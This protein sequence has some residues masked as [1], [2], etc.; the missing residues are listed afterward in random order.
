MKISTPS[1]YIERFKRS[2]VLS[3]GSKYT[4]KLTDPLPLFDGSFIYPKDYQFSLKHNFY[5]ID[6]EHGLN[7]KSYNLLGTVLHYRNAIITHYVKPFY[8]DNTPIPNDIEVVF[9]KDDGKEVS[10]ELKER[11]D[12]FFDSYR[13]IK[14][15]VK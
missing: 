7:P 5:D 9:Y 13:K 3:I 11:I 10:S 6:Y 15:G 4:L 2:L 14:F 12:F 8:G 1:D